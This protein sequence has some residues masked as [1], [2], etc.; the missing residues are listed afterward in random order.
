MKNKSVFNRRF[1]SA[2]NISVSLFI[3]ETK[4]TS[5]EQVQPRAPAT[6]EKL[7]QL[8][9]VVRV[10][11]HSNNKSPPRRHTNQAL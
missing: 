8:F 3:Y 6:I 11:C 4:V 9:R 1:C 2:E 7:L 5:Q 10:V